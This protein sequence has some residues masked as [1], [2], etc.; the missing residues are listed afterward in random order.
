MLWD[1]F[2]IFS[3]DRDAAFSLYGGQTRRQL[4]FSEDPNAAENELRLFPNQSKSEG[5]RHLSLPPRRDGETGIAK[6]SARRF[7]SKVFL[8]LWT[9]TMFAFEQW[10]R[11]LEDE[12]Y[13][14]DSFH[15]PLLKDFAS[16]LP[17]HPVWIVVL[18]W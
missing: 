10:I 15:Y 11:A 5:D 12:A 13:V 7:F 8:L 4:C 16:S 17:I 2:A 18:H 3:G 1:C 6:C 9:Y 14:T